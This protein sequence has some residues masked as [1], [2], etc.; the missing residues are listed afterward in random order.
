MKTKKPMKL[1][2][3]ICEEH[4][5]EIKESFFHPG[6]LNLKLYGAIAPITLTRAGMRRLVAF[7]QKLLEK[8]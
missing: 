5:L 8:K 7:T 1:P 3:A 2:C 6:K 4:D